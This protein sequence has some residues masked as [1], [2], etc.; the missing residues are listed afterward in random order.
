LNVLFVSAEA[1]PF[2]KVGGMA[3]VVGS[4][5]RALRRLGVDARVIM[6]GYGTIKH[7][8]YNLEVLFGFDFPR[9]TGTA[10]VR[11]FTTEQD[12]VPFYFV[13][14]WPFIGDEDS[15]YTEWKWDMPRFLFFS[16]AALAVAWEMSQ[17]MGW[18]PDVFHANDWHTGLIPFLIHES[19]HPVWERTASVITIHNMAYQ[20]DRAGG[21]LGELALR[22]PARSGYQ[23]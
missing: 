22:A 10:H 3:D 9:R 5:P 13:Q 1:A 23:T 17:R 20:G 19:H 4:L 15:V 2:A 6:P 12:G 7:F 21:W 8:D 11:V 16:Q 18:F 14:G